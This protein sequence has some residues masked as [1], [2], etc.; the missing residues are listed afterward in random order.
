MKLDDIL[1]TAGKKKRRKRVGR[2]DGSGLG[3]TSGRGHKGYGSRA[4]AKRRLGYEGGQTPVLFRFPNRGFS[5]V[6]FRTEYQVINVAV[7]QEKFDDGETVDRDALAKAGLIDPD[8]GM[9][10]IL[11][12]GE[13]SKKLTV[14]AEKFS[15]SAAEKIA[16]AGGAVTVIEVK[17]AAEKAA[18]KRMSAKGSKAKAA[19]PKPVEETTDEAASDEPQA[20]E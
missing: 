17:P 2:G 5:N 18:E 8:G 13:L 12:D 14:V 3:K 19:K 10:K 11:G 1:S 4:G 6:N 7:L 16:Q 9:V 15:K 20:S